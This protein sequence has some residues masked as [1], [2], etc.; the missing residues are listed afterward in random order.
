MKAKLLI[1]ATLIINVQI[2]A[3]PPASE[4]K[5]IF[6]ARCAGCHNVNKQIVGPA[7]AG[8]DQRRSMD[9]IVQ[10]VQSSQKLVKNGDK[11]AVALFDKFN[12][13]PMPDHADL[14]ADNVKSIVAYIKEEEKAAVAAKATEAKE[15]EKTQKPSAWAALTGNSAYLFALSAALLLLIASIAFFIRTKKA[16]S[17]LKKA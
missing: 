3:A 16:V 12:K 6:T 13:M 14:T 1:F 11:E 17:Q 9:W 7:L 5:T 4:G 8:I 10:F 15:A 2:F